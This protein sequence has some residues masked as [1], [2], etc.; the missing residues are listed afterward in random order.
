MY[1]TVLVIPRAR[2]TSGFSFMFRRMGVGAQF[3]WVKTQVCA[4]KLR[5]FFDNDIE[6]DACIARHERREPRMTQRSPVMRKNMT[7]LSLR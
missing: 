2:R 3:R 5:A 4:S 1:I 6:P 7:Q